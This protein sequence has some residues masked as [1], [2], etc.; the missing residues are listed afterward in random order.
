MVSVLFLFFASP[1]LPA[2]FVLFPFIFFVFATFMAGVVLS[3]TKRSPI[4]ENQFF[5]VCMK[6]TNK[7]KAG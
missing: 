7:N 1:I 3:H 6:G 5:S 4:L 2:A